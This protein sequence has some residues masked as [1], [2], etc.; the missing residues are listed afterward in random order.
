MNRWRSVSLFK[1]CARSD[2]FALGGEMDVADGHVKDSGAASTTSTLVELL[3]VATVK[4]KS[5]RQ[6]IG[7]VR[8]SLCSRY[9]FTTKEQ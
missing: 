9:C 3:R 1:Q 6:C 2:D 7:A 5:Q 8:T 4:S